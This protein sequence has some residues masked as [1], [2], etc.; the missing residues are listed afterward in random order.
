MDFIYSRQSV[1]KRDS[2]SIESQIELCRYETRGG[3]YR[4][5]SDRGF[6]GGSTD[7]PAFRRML[8]ALRQ[9]E[10]DRVIVYRLD[11]ISRSILDFA[12]MM[13]EFRRLGVAFVSCTEKFD[14]ATPM[15]RAMLHICI[16]FAQ[17]E[18]ETIQ[19]R[20]ADSYAARRRRGFFMGGPVPYGFQLEDVTIDGVH[21][22]RYAPQPEEAAHIRQICAL[23]ADRKHSINDVVR[24]LSAQSAADCRG[25]PWTRE[26]VRETVRN[27][28]YVRADESVYRFYRDAGSEIQSDP[29]LFDG[30][31]GCFLFA[32]EDGRRKQTDPAGARLLIAPH[33][34]L[35]DAEIW[36]ACRRRCLGRAQTAGNRASAT[37]LAGRLKC[38]RC[39]YA[40]VVKRGA[41]GQ[42]Y[43]VCSRRSAA[44][45]CTATNLP[46]ADTVERLT[47]PLFRARLAE[48]MQGA[49]D[50]KA[51]A[52]RAQLAA[53]DA[54]R[55]TLLDRI[56]QANE[57]AMRLINARAAALEQQ[58][59]ELRRALAARKP[60]TAD[61]VWDAL[62]FDGRRAVLDIL[63]RRVTVSA[64]EICVF[65]RI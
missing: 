6:S 42:R 24:L 64:E 51:D 60:P 41:G 26:R 2:V 39:G 45:K 5:F 33:E 56:E 54:E 20:A 28:I 23:Y 46:T 1:D 62:E 47:A 61:G 52:L 34:G 7:R 50:M 10:G 27:P 29:A 57:A 58:E 18:R 55:K 49:P 17:L 30:R 43:L 63:L 37:W 4:V 13:E 22:R 36:L 59:S 19:L 32:A 8:A 53:L 14:T 15:G 11:R 35:V 21:T 25:R 16:V 3:D 9:G 48:V 44:E 12:N 65:W 31:H 40:L 38:A